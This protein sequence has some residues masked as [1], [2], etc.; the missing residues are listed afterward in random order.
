MTVHY[1]LLVLLL[2][3]SGLIS[4]SETALFALTRRDRRAFAM[5]GRLK[6]RA[7]QLMQHSH[8]VLTTVL[9]VNTGV[10][11]LYFAISYVVLRR[12]GMEYPAVAA[13]ASILVFFAIIIVGEILPKAVAK[14]HPTGIA[15]FV[16]PFIGTLQ[17]VTAPV[18]GVL[19]WA[20]VEPLT[21]LIRGPKPDKDEVSVDELRALVEM[22][23]H[24]GVI[25][26]AENRMLQEIVALPEIK[27][28]AVTQPRVDV[29]ACALSEG[30]HSARAKLQETG[31]GKMLVF[32]KDLDDV[33]GLVTVRDLNLYPD[34]PLAGL[35]RPVKFVPEQINLLQLIAHFRTTQTQLAVVVDE[36]GGMTGL[37]TLRDVLEKI[38]GD[39]GGED[40]KTEPATEVIDPNT[41]RLAGDLAVRDWADRFGLADPDM[42]A[43]GHGF[44]TLA[45][46]VLAKLG[47]LPRVGDTVRIRN[48]TLTVERLQGRRIDRILLERGHPDGLA[49][50]SGPKQEAGS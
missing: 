7:A 11:V 49:S 37:V 44:W 28:G 22:T 15:P 34:K 9:I 38:V 18:Q 24:Q 47:R 4:G 35:V 41:Y 32:G 50:A 10:N 39:L 33:R 12:L 23:A 13:G 48:L 46:F 5:G 45:G 25:D 17:T 2:G 36:F 20:L 8:R 1:L 26:S 21:R 30:H 19:G 3:C 14:A 6:R 43:A 29:V 16:A 42:A 27:V 31:L 40:A